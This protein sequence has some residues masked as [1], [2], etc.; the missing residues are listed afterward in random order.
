MFW[1]RENFEKPGVERG[2]QKVQGRLIFFNEPSDVNKAT[3]RQWLKKARKIQWDE[4]KGRLYRLKWRVKNAARGITTRHNNRKRQ[5]VTTGAVTRLPLRE[6]ILLNEKR[7]T[8]KG[9]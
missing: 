8:H 4:K 9:K 5:R 1:S 3:S 6:A 7:I 2:G